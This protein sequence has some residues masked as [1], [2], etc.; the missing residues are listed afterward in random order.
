MGARLLV[1]CVLFALIML[2][3]GGETARK[4]D[5]KKQAD[6]SLVVEPQV[7]SQ[8]EDN[9]EGVEKAS[10][11]NDGEDSEA[12]SEDASEEEGRARGL[13]DRLRS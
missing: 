8:Q 5:T 12:E 4:V 7:E 10:E 9:G 2:F 11:E 3:M 13:E 1:F 6:E